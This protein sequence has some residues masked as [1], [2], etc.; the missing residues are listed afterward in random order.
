MSRKYK[1]HDQQKLHFVTF[2]VIHWID[3]F[4]RDT[5]RTIFIDSLK[6][7]QMNKGLEVYAYVIM[8]NHIHLIIGTSGENV[9]EGIIRDLKAFTSRSIRKAL[10]DFELP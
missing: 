4:I 1:I 5:Y 10:E 9:L 2:T 3:V 8:T 6:Y 7:C